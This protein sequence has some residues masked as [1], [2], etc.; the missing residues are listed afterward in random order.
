MS[1]AGGFESE[2]QDRASQGAMFIFAWIEDESGGELDADGLAGLADSYN[3]TVPNVYDAGGAAMW[4]L[5]AEGGIPYS[6]VFDRGAVIA[7]AGY[8]SVGDVDAVLG[9]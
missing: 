1:E 5:G 9:E 8:L 2:Y 6:V 4:A 7:N 3:M